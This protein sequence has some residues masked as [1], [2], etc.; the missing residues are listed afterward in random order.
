MDKSIIDNF[1]DFR[2]I[3]YAYV[4]VEQG[5]FTKVVAVF[6]KSI[7]AHNYI[8]THGSQFT[9]HKVVLNPKIE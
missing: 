3:T 7:D 5:R 1:T 8:R 9:M 4:I 6:N 2:P